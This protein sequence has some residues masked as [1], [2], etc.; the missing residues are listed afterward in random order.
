M[1]I[2]MDTYFVIRYVQDFH[3][4]CATI[5]TTENCVLRDYIFYN[6]IHHEDICVNKN[7]SNTDLTINLTTKYTNVTHL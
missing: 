2:Q 1:T 3:N 4:I 7:T 5:S 6:L